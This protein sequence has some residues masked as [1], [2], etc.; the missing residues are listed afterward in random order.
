[1][2]VGILHN[3]QLRLPGLVQFPVL[4]LSTQSIC[5]VWDCLLE[6]PCFG[7]CGICQ[8]PC[9]FANSSGNGGVVCR[10]PLQAGW[11]VCGLSLEPG[12]RILIWLPQPR[13]E[14][15]TLDAGQQSCASD[16]HMLSG[17][18]SVGHMP[19]DRCISAPQ[20]SA[21]T[22]ASQCPAPVTVEGWRHMPFGFLQHEFGSAPGMVRIVHVS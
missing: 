6:V 3:L 5:Q 22:H 21:C 20:M 2:V 1:M 7:A 14:G 11:W 4:G 16:C 17:L 10:V 13:A 15:S 8:G 12:C 19:H 18:H 9:I